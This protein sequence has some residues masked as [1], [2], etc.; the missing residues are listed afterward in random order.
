MT[1]TL[2]VLLAIVSVGVVGVHWLRTAVAARD[3]FPEA[4]GTV[5]VEGLGALVSIRRDERGIPHVEAE[6]E[7]DAFFGLGFV[8]A[9]DR[10]AQML[11]LVRLARGR[12]AEVI[13]PAGLPADRVART[14]D[15]GGL[16]SAELARLDDAPRALVEA[17][18]RGVNA[19]IRRVRDGQ[20][21][22]PV[23][24]LDMPGPI[25]DWQPADS[26]A[27]LKLYSWGLS[28]A[29]D[30][31]LVL[32]D[33]IERLG[34]LGARR[35]FPQSPRRPGS[36]SSSSVMAG[37][38]R[39]LLTDPLRAATRLQGRAIGS[40]AWV[41]G[42]GRTENGS[43]I[44]VADAHLETTA[45]SLFYAAHFRGG[46]L[47]V[48]GATIPGIP[49]VWSGHNQRLAWGSTHARAVTIDL[50]QEKLGSRDTTSYY[51]GRSW[52]KLIERVETLEVRGAPT[53][54]MVVRSTPHGPLL[55][56]IVDGDREP[57]ALA[58]AGARPNGRSGVATLIALARARD[59]AEFLDVAAQ[60]EEPP[61]ALVYATS[62]GAAGMQVAGWIPRRALASGLV[63]LPG[64]A[65]W[66]D[67]DGRVDFED[68]PRSR[69]G[70][71]GW[72]IA[73]DNVFARAEGDERIEWLWRS[74]TRAR[75]I[76]AL[77]RAAVAAGPVALRQMTAMQTDV[78]MER[79]REL[80]ARALSFVDAGDRIGA[81]AVE[82]VALLQDWNG[83]SDPAST[84][85]AAYHLFLASL[86][87][88]L[89]EP[90]LGE[91]L[92]RR[93][94]ALP[95]VDPDQVV[96]EIVRDA[97]G[98]GTVDSW[99]DPEVVGEAVRASLRETWFNLSYR[100]GS[101]RSKWQW[102]RLHRLAFRSFLPGQRVAGFRGTLPPFDHGGG[103]ATLNA[104]G[105]DRTDPFA[106][107]VASTFRFAVDV[108]TLDQALV[109][110]APGQ[111]G[112]PGHPHF[113]DGV[114]RWREGRPHL[115]ITSPLVVEESSRS[116]LTLEP[117][118]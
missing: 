21:G 3:A 93:Y 70:A 61:L 89:L 81:E 54:E 107:R 76:D 2:V 110:L 40:S 105:Y 28:A 9:Q 108:A 73:A 101:N 10:L 5:A 100:L 57:L 84:G 14:L 49:V 104:G 63:P 60:H 85:A 59:E 87:R 64:R 48:A 72:A 31:S 42:G 117:A 102:G 75:R 114:Q 68:L 34:G 94:L 77:L 112:H 23:A 78:A 55:E 66:Y 115:L 80:I 26:L 4:S 103:G 116:V 11:W 25:E 69:A 50:Y 35:F 53:E 91:E 7:E 17:Y 95:Q 20:A 92:M 56:T 16:A 99:S 45:P 111:S 79:A 82:V 19:H 65:R 43:P 38:P 22:A 113:D 13:G 33:L 118:P 8:H 97:T 58:W 88:Q 41:I 67:W 96:F 24:L 15:L 109:S 90:T 98:F 51:D 18:A 30:A 29:F 6:G 74:G 47:D 1:R 37:A 32:N 62:A 52:Q 83:R 12:S 106:V 46:G 39:P 71:D 36:D 27:V 44:L 86:T